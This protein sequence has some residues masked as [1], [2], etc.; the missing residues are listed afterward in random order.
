MPKPADIQLIIEEAIAE[1]LTASLP[2]LRE[3]IVQRTM[4]Q[5]E[6]L[7]APP[8]EISP[9][10]LLNAA[11][12]AIHEMSSQAEV[13]RRLLEGCAQFAARSALFVVK[14]RAIAGWL[15]FGFEEN[16]S[17]KNFSL[18]TA[19]GPVAQ[20]IQDRNPVT[21]TISD[22][23]PGFASAMGTPV[24]SACQVLPLVVRQKVAA[25][26]Y[27]DAGLAPEGKLDAHALQLLMRFTGLWIE[28]LTLR[29]AAP[30]DVQAVPAAVQAGNSP[31]VAPEVSVAREAP[32]A[33]SPEDAEIH[34]KARRF[35]KLLVE[36]IKLYN[37]QKV[38]EGRQNKDLYIRLQDE[39]EKS[40][41]TYARRYAESTAASGDY[42]T[43]ELIRVLADNDVTLMGAGYSR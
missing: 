10:E 13:L 32:A 29:K 26:V 9:S 28:L 15:A 8:L 6:S 18:D 24:V 30:E 37:G 35:A 1:V 21:T 16:D 41:A 14:G 42:F 20:A 19:T 5:L 25:V 11:V 3:E 36:E 4:E 12:V 23:D 22:F 17:I 2:R 34:K 7:P 31:A 33:L 43:E 39:I 40:K 38:T 27:V